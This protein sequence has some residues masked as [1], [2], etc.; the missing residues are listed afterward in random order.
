MTTVSFLGLGEMGSALAG[1]VLRTD[2]P[3]I[4]W[5]RTATRTAPLVDAGAVAANTPAAATDADLIVVCLFD[6]ASVHDVLDPLADRLTGKS[7]LNLTTTSPTA[8]ANSPDGPPRSAP[9]TSTAA[10]W[11]PPR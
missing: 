2:H 6:H 9:I 7:I 5:N 11:P 4:V 8:P 10:S 1:G 3:T